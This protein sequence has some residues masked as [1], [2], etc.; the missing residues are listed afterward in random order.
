[1]FFQNWVSHRKARA[2]QAI[3]TLEE[4]L[5]ER[6]AFTCPPE[7][8]LKSKIL[9]AIAYV[10]SIGRR[11]ASGLFP[12][13]VRDFQRQDTISLLRREDGKASTAK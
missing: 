2:S 12:L 5:A 4:S 10:R 11:F 7:Q 9:N 1:M 3:F 8:D 6:C 13:G